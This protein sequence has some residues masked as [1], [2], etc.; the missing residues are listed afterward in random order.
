MTASALE[1]ERERCLA[2]GM[3]DFLTK[4]VDAAELERVIR[5]WVQPVADR[6]ASPTARRPADPVAD[7]APTSRARTTGCS[8]PTGSRCSTSL[9][10]D[11]VSFFERTA[12]AFI[13]PRRR[14]SW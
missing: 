8:T 11:G 7:R 4:P 9:V 5:E 2:V 1:G 14:A 3:D 13:G 12:A 10:K 6:R